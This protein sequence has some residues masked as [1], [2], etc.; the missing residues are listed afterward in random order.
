[1]K[2]RS[3]VNWR[4]FFGCLAVSFALAWVVHW[5]F[6]FNYWGAWGIIMFAWVA[7]AISTFFDDDDVKTAGSIEKPKD[8]TNA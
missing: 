3:L 7:V 4:V 2:L 8:S 5:L 1:M 6:G